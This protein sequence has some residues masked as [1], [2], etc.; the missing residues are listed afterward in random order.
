MFCVISG[1]ANALV[2]R[3]G[4]FCVEDVNNQE[5]LQAQG[6]NIGKDMMYYNIV[7]KIWDGMV[8]KMGEVGIG[9]KD[10]LALYL[11]ICA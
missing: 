8:L 11:H 7:M 3:D 9:I 1:P 6:W 2:G 4:L 5:G 10:S